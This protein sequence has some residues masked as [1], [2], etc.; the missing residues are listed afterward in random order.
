M[1]N[2]LNMSLT[3][4]LRRFVDMR[5]NDNDVYLTP[6]EYINIYSVQYQI[7]CHCRASRRGCSSGITGLCGPID[8][9]A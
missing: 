6:S 3:T 7:Q 5:A 1:S 9:L 2:S 4:E 8:Q